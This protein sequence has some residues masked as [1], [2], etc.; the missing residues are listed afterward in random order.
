MEEGASS[1]LCAFALSIECARP[2]L[3]F[4]FAMLVEK[5][6]LITLL[7]VVTAALLLFAGVRSVGL[8]VVVP[9]AVST[10]S[11]IPAIPSGLLA[12]ACVSIL[13]G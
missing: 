3:A 2:L 6:D 13:D 7:R 4:V 1:A 10:I 12:L 5:G 11:T 9:V 8:C